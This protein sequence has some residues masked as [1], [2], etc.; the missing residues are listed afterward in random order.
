MFLRARWRPEQPHKDRDKEE[1]RG[2]RPRH[3]LRPAPGWR[4]LS[5]LC[6]RSRGAALL[7][8]S[9]DRGV[10][11]FRYLDNKGFRTAFAIEVLVE[12]EAQL[13]HVHPHGAV[14]DNAVVNRLAEYGAADAM[15]GQIGDMPMEASLRHVTEK[16]PDPCRFLE[17]RAGGDALNQLPAC[18]RFQVWIRFGCTG[19]LCVV[20]KWH[21]PIPART[22]RI[23]P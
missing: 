11:A 20:L 14:I 2:K 10:R 19:R 8:V 18:I 7:L 17:G 1:N 22:R 6:E 9:K 12:L 16:I 21:D 15:L 3:D 4:R 13:A 23:I 5:H